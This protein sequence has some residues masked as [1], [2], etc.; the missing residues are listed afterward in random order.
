[1]SLIVRTENGMHSHDRT[2]LSRLGFEDPD[3]KDPRHDLACQYLAQPDVAARLAAELFREE[4]ARW[5][6]FSRCW[7][8]AKDGDAQAQNVMLEWALRR[9]PDYGGTAPQLSKTRQEFHLTK[10]QG[11]YATTVGFVDLLLEF[12]SSS[13]TSRLSQRYDYHDRRYEAP[14]YQSVLYEA[15]TLLRTVLVEVKIAPVDLGAIL[16]QLNLYRS[17]FTPHFELSRTVI[18][19]HFPLC[20]ADVDALANE[21]IIC[22]RLGPAFD[23]FARKRA[24]EADEAE[25][26]GLEL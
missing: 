20:R 4:I 12:A 24:A 18:A 26:G 15:R 6:E 8:L 25:V 19:C 10:G 13:V 21:K 17:Y 11:Q 7:A 1:M 23:E 14:A 5:D 3:K 16:R 22:A 2:F 9:P